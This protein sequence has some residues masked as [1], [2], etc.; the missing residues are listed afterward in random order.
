MKGKKGGFFLGYANE[1]SDLKLAKN[2]TTI[3]SNTCMKVSCEKIH[4]A[5]KKNKK[6]LAL[7]DKRFH[8]DTIEKKE[9]LTN[10]MRKFKEIKDLKE[11]RLKNCKD[12]YLK[13]V[14]TCVEYWDKYYRTEAFANNTIAIKQLDELKVLIK[15]Q[16]TD[17][18]Y[19]RITLLY[20]Q[21]IQIATIYETNILLD[22]LEIMKPKLSAKELSIVNQ[23]NKLMQN[24]F[25]A[26]TIIK[27]S[28]TVKKLMAEFNKNIS[29]K[30]LF[31]ELM[32]KA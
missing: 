23:L 10:E 5:I 26:S 11:C 2:R 20:G 19:D 24:K 32:K 28:E 8:A 7:Q 25:A 22:V 27:M 6:L 9:E 30:I 21:L 31:A 12:L 3:E 29:N 17:D 4:D 16:M 13:N 15:K 1:K 14:K 18:N